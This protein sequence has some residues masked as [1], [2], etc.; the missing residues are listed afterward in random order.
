MRGNEDG[1]G[2]I[3]RFIGG[4]ALA[5]VAKV[6]CRAFADAAL[7]RLGCEAV[8]RYYLWQLEGP[9]EHWFRGGRMGG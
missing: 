5:D 3:L 8:R 7:T 9:H 2:V 1:S 4:A 6:H